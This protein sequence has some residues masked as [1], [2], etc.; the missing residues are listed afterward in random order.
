MNDRK[1]LERIIRVRERLKEVRRADLSQAQRACKDADEELKLR[2]KEEAAALERLASPEGMSA[3][4]L[5]LRSEMAQTAAQDRKE[6]E[7]KRTET[8]SVQAA[9]RE[10]VMQASKDVKVLELFRLRLLETERRTQ[11]KREQEAS[12]EAA[13]RGGDSIRTDHKRGGK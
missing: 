3:G 4:E 10:A 6:A 2:T 8:A 9:C 13:L 5:F 12:D 11:A 1:R 7:H